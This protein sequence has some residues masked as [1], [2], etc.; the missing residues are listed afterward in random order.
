MT[1]FSGFGL[2]TLLTPVFMFFF[3]IKTAIALTAVIHFLNNLFKVSLTLR[4][5]HW[6]TV[7]YFGIASL[8][9][10]F[11]GAKV[12]HT[13]NDQIL[14]SYSLF[15]KVYTVWFFKLLMA[16]L[17]VFFAFFEMVKFME[18][19]LSRKLLPLGGLISGFFGGLS[20]H[21]GAL[22]SAFLLKSGLSKE[23][24]IATGIIIAC[25][26]DAGR[27]FIYSSY[28]T[29]DVIEANSG[30]LLCAVLSAFAGAFL[31]NKLLKKM[32]FTFLQYTVSV[33]IILFSI[34]L[35]MGII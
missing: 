4:N 26:V 11:A 9:G 10:A 12:L 27:L 7:F 16:L 3:D 21:Q 35:A 15:D 13:V 31:G 18:F 2:G 24:F 14:L 20:G 33:F 19:N 28:F 29:V 17:L 30:I 32:T 8:L 22:R 23:Q 1:F 34:A 25:M 5:T 6:N